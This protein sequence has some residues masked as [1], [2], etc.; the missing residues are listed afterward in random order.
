MQPALPPRQTGSRARGG[1]AISSRPAHGRNVGGIDNDRSG[2]TNR[3]AL[4]DEAEA[5]D[6]GHP[7]IGQDRMERLGI[8]RQFGEGVEAVVSGLYLDASG[9][10]C[11]L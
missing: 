4:F 2:V 7:K 11:R 5:I 1:D 8:F 6:P 10:E 3:L 9:F